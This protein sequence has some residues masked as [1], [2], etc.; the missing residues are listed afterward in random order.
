MSAVATPVRRPGGVLGRGWPAGRAAIAGPGR[1]SRPPSVPARSAP[2]RRPGAPGSSRSR[3]RSPRRPPRPPWPRPRSCAGTP[4]EV[5]EQGRAGP[6][7]A[8]RARR[9]GRRGAVAGTGD[10]GDAEQQLLRGD[11]PAPVPAA[12]RAVA[13]VPDQPL[14]PQRTGDAVPARRT[15]R[16][17]RRSAAGRP[18]PG[19]SCGPP[20]AAPSS[21]GPGPRRAW[22]PDAERGRELG[23]GQVTARLLPPQRRAAAG[24]R[25]RAS[26]PPRPARGAAR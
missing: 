12:G 16:P 22:L 15:C 8:A 25:R 2:R 10:R 4:V 17:V 7:T 3:M 9:T 18:A 23:A 11:Q 24:R 1:W 5:A 19:R 26:G 14:A 13:D 20:R 6:A 21:A